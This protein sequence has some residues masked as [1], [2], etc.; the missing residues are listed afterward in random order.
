MNKSANINESEAPRGRF[1]ITVKGKEFGANGDSE[2]NSI[3]PQSY[4]KVLMEMPDSTKEV[5][6]FVCVVI[7]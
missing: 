2:R 3:H 1:M 4:E 5:R 6:K 7:Y